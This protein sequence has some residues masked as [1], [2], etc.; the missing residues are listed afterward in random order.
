MDELVQDLSNHGYNSFDVE[1]FEVPLIVKQLER[2]TNLS[3]QVED[4]TMVLNTL[5]TTASMEDLVNPGPIRRKLELLKDIEKRIEEILSSKEKILA[6]IQRN[7]AAGESQV[8]CVESSKQVA[9]KELFDGMREQL[10]DYEGVLA[11]LEW[12]SKSELHASN[13]QKIQSILTLLNQ[14]QA[15]FQRSFEA[16]EA[17][18]ALVENVNKK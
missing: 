15:R 1:S 7:H 13:V 14:F 16:S 17:L 3:K 12:G 9:F 10:N 6:F 8:L 18:T 5:Q 11:R 4:S 2:L